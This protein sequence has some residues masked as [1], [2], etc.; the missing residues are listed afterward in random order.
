VRGTWRSPSSEWGK[1]SKEVQVWL[2]LHG[3][4]L[5][6]ELKV[7]K[8]QANS[9]KYGVVAHLATRHILS[10]FHLNIYDI[11]GH[12]LL[13]KSMAQYAAM[14]KAESLWLV[15]DS[16]GADTKAVVRRTAQK[17]AKKAWW[18]ALRAN[19]YDKFGRNLK[20]DSET[21][22]V[23]K[24]GRPTEQAARKALLPE[25]SCT[26]RLNVKDPKLLL[27]LRYAELVEHFKRLIQRSIEPKMAENSKGQVRREPTTPESSNAKK[28]MGK[29]VSFKKKTPE[30]E[31]DT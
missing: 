15:V 11:R 28:K 6:G 16:V 7:V 24:T 18:A 12:P 8:G 2:R 25:L 29:G 26:V 17:R 10:H 19:G 20:L 27:K 30:T 5:S 4:G 22:D 14:D 21:S 9:N 31:V 3:F 23:K 1:M 13:T